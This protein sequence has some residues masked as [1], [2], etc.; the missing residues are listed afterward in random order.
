[1]TKSPQRAQRC[2]LKESSE[3]GSAVEAIKCVLEINAHA[4]MA[5]SGVGECVLDG[6]YNRFTTIGYTYA[7]LVR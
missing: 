1:M 5:L 7:K 3:H 2:V 4:K 6:V